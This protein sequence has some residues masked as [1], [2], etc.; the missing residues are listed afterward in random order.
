MSSTSSSEYKSSFAPIENEHSKILILGSLPGEKSLELQEYYGHPRNKFWKV[1]EQLTDSPV[2]DF[3]SEKKVLLLQHHIA[4]WDIVHQATR[5]GSLDTAIK[6]VEPN[7][8]TSFIQ[9]HKHLKAIAFNG[10]KS[11]QLYDRYFERYA[12]LDYF[13]LPST[14]P[15]NATKRLEEIL[16][17]WSVLKDYL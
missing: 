13:T 4:L 5:I 14:S 6:N 15:A 17:H 12:H 7:D 1:I 9:D 10:Q 11:N 2:P 3:F 16:Q 8:L